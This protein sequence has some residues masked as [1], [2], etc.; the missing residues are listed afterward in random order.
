MSNAE[1]GNFAL[2]LEKKMFLIQRL[3]HFVLLTKYTKCV[4][5]PR[6]FKLSYIIVY[7]LHLTLFPFTK[8]STK[9][10]IFMPKVHN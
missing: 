6:A 7:F 9:C 10:V 5:G 3:G 8:S 1:N 2:N 4:I